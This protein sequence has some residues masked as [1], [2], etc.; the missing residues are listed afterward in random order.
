MAGPALALRWPVTD[1][2]TLRDTLTRLM[3]YGMVGLAL[4]F[5]GYLLYLALTWLGIGP[6][7]TMT[8]LYAVGAV[9]G[10]FGHRKLAF[11]Y[12]GSVLGSAARYCL[13]HLC[14]YGLNFALLYILVDRLNYPHQW[15]QAGAIFVVAAFLFICFNFLVFPS[16]RAATAQG[17]QARP[18]RG[19]AEG[20]V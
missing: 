12:G 9:T 18:S 6:K 20:E 17:G 5:A 16:T 3:R 10:Y 19:T 14:G 4:N 2:I 13:A 1:F 7:T 8:L 15:I 11:S